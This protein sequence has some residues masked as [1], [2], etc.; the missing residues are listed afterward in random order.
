[1]YKSYIN[2]DEDE[3]RLWLADEDP[4]A[5]DPTRDITAD[6]VKEWLEAGDE[7]V[8]FEQADVERDYV[9][10]GDREIEEVD[11]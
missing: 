11:L 1:M 5:V 3:I 4:D 9:L 6:D 7:S 10:V 8:W 2:V